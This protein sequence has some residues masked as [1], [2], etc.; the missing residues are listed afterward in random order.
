LFSCV[1]AAQKARVLADRGVCPFFLPPFGVSPPLFLDLWIVIFGIFQCTAALCFPSPVLCKLPHC[2]F[3]VDSI[4]P[5]ISS[6]PSWPLMQSIFSFL[7]NT[8]PFDLRRFF[9]PET[10]LSHNGL[11]FFPDP[12]YLVV[13]QFAVDQDKLYFPVFNSSED[14]KPRVFSKFCLGCLGLHLPLFPVHPNVPSHMTG[15]LEGRLALPNVFPPPLTP[16]LPPFP[17]SCCSKTLERFPFM[18]ASVV[19]SFLFLF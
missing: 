18:F 7:F 9:S 13:R 17:F 4:W 14:A 2:L 12:I 5:T 10:H 1:L 6:L 11:D 16:H 3:P 15:V 8:R 19:P